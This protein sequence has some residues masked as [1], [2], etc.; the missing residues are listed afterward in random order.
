MAAGLV[1]EGTAIWDVR[2]AVSGGCARGDFPRY[3][4]AVSAAVAGL[5]AAPYAEE[6]VRC[7]RTARFTQASAPKVRRMT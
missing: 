5:I 7:A 4:A 3:L 2:A 1:H 6:T